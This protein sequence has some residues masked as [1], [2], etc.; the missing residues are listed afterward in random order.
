[1]KKIL[2]TLSK[3][4]FKK[5][6]LHTV[7]VIA[8]VYTPR[9]TSAQS[10][11]LGTV[12]DFILFSTDG[13]VTNTGLSE[14]TGNVGTNKGPITGFG[15][16]NG[17]MHDQDGASAACAADLLSLYD[18]LNDETPTFFPSALLGNG[19]SLIAGVYEMFSKTTL[20]GNL[21]L[22]GKGDSNAVFIFQIQGAFSTDAASKVILING[23]QAC[24]VFWKV[25]GL[26]DMATQ[27]YMRGTVVANNAA[28]VTSAL[29]SLEGRLLTTTGA[30]TVNGS[31]TYMPTGCNAPLLTGPAAPPLATTACYAIFSGNGAVTNTGVTYITGDVGTNV[32]LA[33]GFDALL[34]T[35]TIHS[36]P[37]VSTAACAA[38]LQTMYD[39][40]NVLTPDI[41]L[42]YPAQFG[43]NLVLTPHTYLLNTATAFTDTLYLNAQGN[44]DGVF[45][46]KVNGA[47]ATSTFSRVILENG[48][49]AKNVFWQVEGMVTIAKNSVFYGTLIANNAAIGLT[50]GD[51]IYGRALTTDGALSTVSLVTMIPNGSCTPLPIDWLYFTGS[52]V[53]QNVSL[54]W[55]T[56]NDLNNNFYTVE[57]SSTGNDYETLATINSFSKNDN[58]PSAYSYTDIQPYPLG[59]YRISQTDKD[60]HQTFS[61]SIKV[62]MDIPKG[63]QVQPY[64]GTSNINLKVSGAVAGKGVIELYSIDG[65][66]IETQE[67][68]L[69]AEPNVY[70]IEKPLQ[71]GVYII[72]L[73]SNGE[74]LY[75]GKVMVLSDY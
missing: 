24:N 37:D 3:I 4:T 50:I 51:S 15:N 59:Y 61:K 40:I 7:M 21:Y 28:I 63:L 12:A 18:Q 45:V 8:L 48:A 42:L 2:H 58:T 46:I 31:T 22:D 23:T 68:I 41:E 74:K 64:V 19:D 44:P 62:N 70:Q 66:I 49:Q 53:Q 11:I 73:K 27:T 32:G 57:R 52:P 29:D 43:N 75:T 69:T 34:V 13:A 17:V 38:D 35:G 55:S 14:F 71:R 33:A 65:N 67:V 56:A 72:S 47:L 5:A 30:V 25:E 20:S 36:K 54:Q 16:V 6:L 1:M 26:V 39:Y 9:I 60:G 10:P